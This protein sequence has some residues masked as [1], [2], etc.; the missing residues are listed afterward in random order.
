MIRGTTPTHTFNIPFDTSAIT[1]LR[2]IYSQGDEQILVKELPDC[3][4]DGNT[5][6]VKLTQEDTFKFDCHKNTVQ[7]QLRVLTA[8]NDA[9][10][11]DPVSVPVFKCLDSEVLV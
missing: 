9:L 11:S 8:G 4:V 6:S 7:I 10:A 3:T 1:A 2:I 5:I